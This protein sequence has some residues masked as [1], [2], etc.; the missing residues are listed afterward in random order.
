VNVKLQSFVSFKFVGQVSG[1]RAVAATSSLI[2]VSAWKHH[3]E[4]VHAVSLFDAEDGVLLRTLGGEVGSGD[5]LLSRPFGVRFTASGHQVLVADCENDRVSVF[6]TTDGAWVR[7]AGP[8]DYHALKG[9]Y[10]VLPVAG[11]ALVATNG[12]QPIVFLP[13]GEAAGAGDV[14]VLGATGFED[15][16]FNNPTALTLVP[17]PGGLHLFVLEKGNERFQVFGP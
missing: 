9:P 12:S 17:G 2:A 16:E 10:D 6:S 4:G 1:P 15:G 8:S 3:G 13:S 14:T 7:H 11:G 5:G